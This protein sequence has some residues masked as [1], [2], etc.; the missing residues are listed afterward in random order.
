MSLYPTLFSDN[1]WGHID[2]SFKSTPE[3]IPT[4]VFPRCRYTLSRPPWPKM[5][6][7][8]RVDIPVALHGTPESG[9]AAFLHPAPLVA[10]YSCIPLSVYCFLQGVNCL[11]FPVLVY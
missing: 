4:T 9:R 10:D 11:V 3:R 7:R 6:L 2:H 8:S 1:H 5:L